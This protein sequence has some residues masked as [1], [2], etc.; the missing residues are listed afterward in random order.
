MLVVRFGL[1]LLDS[2]DHDSLA[3]LSNK[4]KPS[5]RWRIGPAM[6]ALIQ[7]PDIGRESWLSSRLLIS[8]QYIGDVRYN[9][10][11]VNASSFRLIG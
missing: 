10:T 8:W 3:G 1:G 5:G 2:S 11:R 9:P 7:S 6:T 4:P